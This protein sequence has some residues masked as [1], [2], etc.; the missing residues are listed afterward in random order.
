MRKREH[1]ALSTFKMKE[2]INIIGLTYLVSTLRS[3]SK[4]SKLGPRL[5]VND[6]PTNKRK[7]EH[8]LNEIWI[9]LWCLYL[10][11]PDLV[12]KGDRTYMPRCQSFC[13]QCQNFSI[14]GPVDSGS[15]EKSYSA[16]TPPCNS[17]EPILPTIAT[18]GAASHTSD[19]WIDLYPTI[20]VTT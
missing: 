11:G 17:V 3:S 9:Y 7:K 19:A 18:T 5:E 16:Y 1:L 6:S 12:I 20:L 4:L 14:Q 10:T 13:H 2:W 8:K 15:I